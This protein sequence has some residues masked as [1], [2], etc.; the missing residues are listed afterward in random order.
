MHCPV[1]TLLAC[2]ALSLIRLSLSQAHAFAVVPHFAVVTLDELLRLIFGD[3]VALANFQL[4]PVV[5]A[6][7]THLTASHR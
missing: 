6:D 2:E 4:A 3:I 7:H 5:I 1:I